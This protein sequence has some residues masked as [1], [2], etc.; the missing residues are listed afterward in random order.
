MTRAFC[1]PLPSDRPSRERAAET[2]T[3]A[4]WGVSVRG[5]SRCHGV[6]E[7]DDLDDGEWAVIRALL[8]RCGPGGPDYRAVVNGIL[9]QQRGGRRWH[10]LPARY[11]PWHRCA[12]R[13]RLW[14]TDGTWH[15]VLTS[16]AASRPLPR[17]TEQTRDTPKSSLAREEIDDWNSPWLP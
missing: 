11:G 6:S 12:E 2:S 4:D 15:N 1:S 16:L 9:W 7:C 3:H 10:D 5:E 13:L 8:P 17:R 14:Q